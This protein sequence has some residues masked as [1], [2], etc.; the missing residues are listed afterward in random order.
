M[1]I[2]DGYRATTIADIARHARVAVDTVYA[3]V[4]R[5]PTV[6]REV[7][8]TALSGADDAVPARRRDYVARTR[9][10]I[11][12]P[13]KI[14]AYVTGLVEVQ[15]RLAPVYLALR[16]AASTDP[17]SAAQW[18][19]VSERRARNMREFAADLRAT[20]ELRP[21]LTNDQI[22]D[23][24]WSMNGPE[25]WALLAHDRGWPPHS[26]GQHLIDAWERL[27]LIRAAAAAPPT[28][29]TSPPGPRR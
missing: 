16:D 15:T 22:A 7:I 17:D 10:A 25:Y 5:K 9:A 2:R 14:E 28:T 20:G 21:D 8:E 13:A 27:F 26:I 4:G 29:I 18:R 3:T 6:L 24:I 11:G 23:V 1:F 19:E 12:A